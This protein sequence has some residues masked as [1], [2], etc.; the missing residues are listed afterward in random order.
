MY[1]DNGRFIVSRCNE[2]YFKKHYSGLYSEIIEF[3]SKYQLNFDNF[4]QLLWHYHYKISKPIYCKYCKNKEARFKGLNKG[5][6]EFCCKEH[7]MKYAAINAK[8]KRILTNLKQYGVKNIMHLNETKE[9]I[10]QTNLERY[11][12]EN[13]MFNEKIKNQVRQ[14]NLKR[15]GTKSVL[16]SYKIRNKIKATNLK[17]YGGHP[18]Q[19]S[20]VRKKMMQTRYS[21]NFNEI[22][23]DFQFLNIVEISSD[24]FLKIKCNE[25]NQIYKIKQS[26]L[27]QRINI[28]GFKNPCTFCNPI[29]DK[30]SNF[31]NLII[32]YLKQ[33][34]IIVHQNVRNIISPLELDV[35]IPEKKIAIEF[36]GLYWHSELF[37]DK[38]YH[39]NKTLECEKQGIQLIHIFEDEWLYKQEIVKSRLKNILGLTENKIYARKTQIQEV[40][41]ADAKIFLNKNHIQGNINSKIRLG[42]YYNNELV[43][44]M[45][46]GNLRKALGSTS[47]DGSYEILRFCNKLNYYIIGSAS[48]LFKYFKY[49]YKPIKIISYVDRRWSAGNLYRQLGFIEL[50][51]SKPNYWYII[52]G[53]RE[54]RYKYRKSELIKQGFD[55]DKT[56]HEIMLERN[57]YRIYDCG[58]LK[59][60][61]KS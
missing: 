44:L 46:F 56:E 10:K 25:C 45:T 16:S 17:R 50:Q 11:G 43:S 40:S 5:Y 35:Y 54:Y 52:N 30:K 29:N 49:N 33:F 6:N 12:V 2:I 27:K 4:T 51:P 3:N 23:N 34:N 21:N 36:N 38:N 7:S 42:L 26:L 19:N 58:N 39:L 32:N 24:R 48:K 53:V 61:H 59:F 22:K 28:N 60:Q 1:I 55:K 8:E 9:K 15:Y 13:P 31:E 47:E 14:T 57:I 37:K 41:S 20:E 18:M